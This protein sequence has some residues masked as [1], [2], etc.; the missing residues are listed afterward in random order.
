MQNKFLALFV[1]VGA[2]AGCASST[3]TATGGRPATQ[4]IGGGS[5]VGSIVV[6]NRSESDVTHLSYPMDAV[7]R[8]LPGVFDS[9]A[10]PLTVMDP[11]QKRIGNE[12]FK[13]RARLGK[14]PLS[15]YLD[16]GNTQIGPNAD[17]YDVFM[18]IVTT[19]RP[20]GTAGSTI[21]TVIEAQSKPITY[22]QGYSRCT[23]KTSLEAKIAELVVARL[24]P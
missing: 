4:T 19:V 17:S 11:T 16:C 3:S 21:H 14:A 23:S 22:N 10:V 20:E 2:L 24:T 1:V 8:V 6:A 13:L 12:G 5:G 7:W 15:R 9:I 18:T